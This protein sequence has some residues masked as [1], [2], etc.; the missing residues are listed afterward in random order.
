LQ[1]GLPLFQL[2]GLYEHLQ[3]IKFRDYKIQA[4]LH[5]VE[6]KDSG[7]KEKAKE[8]PKVPLFRDPSEYDRMSAEQKDLETQRMMGLH[9]R[10][11]G[12]A[13]NKEPQV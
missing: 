3:H 1:G 11:S 8:D 5:G 4:S 2:E 9:K 12:D 10:W 7:R 13:I 6:I